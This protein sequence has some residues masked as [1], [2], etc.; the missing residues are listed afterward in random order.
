MLKF[1]ADGNVNGGII[2]G[3]TIANIKSELVDSF[4]NSQTRE[5]NFKG[6]KNFLVSLK[7]GDVLPLLSKI[8]LDGSF[9]TNKINPNDIDMVLLFN[10]S[11][12]NIPK[13]SEFFEQRRQYFRQ[14]G[15][16]FYCDAYFTVDHTLIPPNDSAKASFDKQNK[17]WMGQFGFDREGKNKGML[18]IGCPEGSEL[19]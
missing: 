15:E 13:I 16:T 6:L 5:R 17:Y 7:D 19:Q 10:P 1:N 18:E 9:L 4:P 14:I 3:L 12:D 2:K 8:W 11:D